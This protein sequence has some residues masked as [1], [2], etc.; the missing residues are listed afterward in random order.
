MRSILLISIFICALSVEAT[1]QKSSPEVITIPVVVHVVYNNTQQNISDD[2]V[3]SQ[4]LVLN[5]DYRKKNADASYI[6][7]AF[8]N[9]AGDAHIEFKLATIDPAGMPTNGIIR[10][11]T[12]EASFAADDKIKS[13][14]TGGDDGWNRNQYLNLWTGNITGGILGYA[15][16][17]GCAA[18]KDGVVIRY[19][20][21]GTTSNVQPPFNKGRTATHEIGHWFGLRHIWGDSPCGDDR[22]EDTPPQAGPTRG[23]P[24]G[25][26]VTCTSGASGNMYMNFMDFTDDACTSMFTNGQVAKI[27]EVFAAD[28]ARYALLSS[29]KA[30]GADDIAASSAILDNVSVYPNPAVNELKVSFNWQDDLTGKQLIIYNHLGQVARQAIITKK[31]M[32][33]NLSGLKSGIYFISCG[34]RARKFLKID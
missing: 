1:S 19:N 23:C 28:G 21:F 13:S 14:L 5:K 18:A 16:A 22:I 3:R 9:L 15:S 34:G 29:D 32:I 8:K 26:I 17:P 25:V 2:Q 20:A 27:H 7:A 4:I 10:K 24:S 11:S 31:E 33:I 30:A 12:S 6:P